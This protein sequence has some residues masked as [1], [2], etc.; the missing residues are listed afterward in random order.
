MFILVKVS[1]ILFATSIV[2]G[3]QQNHIVNVE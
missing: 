2:A 3:L 1:E